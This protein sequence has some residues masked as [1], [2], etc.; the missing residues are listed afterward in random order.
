[1]VLISRRYPFQDDH[2]YQNKVQGPRSLIVDSDGLD[3]TSVSRPGWSFM[4]EQGPRSLIHDPWSMILNPWSL[5]HDP[6][7]MILDPIHDPWSIFLDPWSLIHD[8]WSM[9]HDPWSMIHIPWSLIHDPW[10]LMGSLCSADVAPVRS[11]PVGRSGSGHASR[12]RIKDQG[13]CPATKEHPR[14]GVNVILR[15]SKAPIEIYNS[16]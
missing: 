13:P 11:G 4:L 1:M 2:S 16:R 7:S 3:L 6:W 5:I 9:I 8:P 14:R 15:Q 10:S 12:I